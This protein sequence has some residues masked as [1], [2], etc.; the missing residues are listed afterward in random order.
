MS[1][2]Q[3]LKL[4]NN[5]SLWLFLSFNAFIAITTFFAEQ[6]NGDYRSFED[7]LTIRMGGI[8]I[9]PLIIFI[10]NGVLSSNQK[11]VIAFWRVHDT[12][13]GHR[14]FSKHGPKDYRVDMNRLLQMHGPL[15]IDAKSQNI[16]WY[17]IFKRHSGN[18]AIAKSHKDFLLARDLTAI[19]TLLFIIAGGTFIV[20]GQWP[21]NLFYLLFLF[22]QYILMCIL[23]Q[24]YGCRLVTNVLAMESTN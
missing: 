9:A 15:P 3:N 22:A 14:A 11:A 24:N 21:Y 17:K 8:V 13:P 4:M 18:V 1:Q 12:L 7:F 2:E 23:T 16:L 6:L 5:R 10:I 20:I 19:S